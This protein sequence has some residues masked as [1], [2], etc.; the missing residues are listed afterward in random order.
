MGRTEVN[1]FLVAMAIPPFRQNMLLNIGIYMYVYILFRQN[2]NEK[3]YFRNFRKIF[4][5]TIHYIRTQ[6][7]TSA[8]VLTAPATS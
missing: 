5:E 4:A 2:L 6:V 1:V 3:D 8:S 7:P